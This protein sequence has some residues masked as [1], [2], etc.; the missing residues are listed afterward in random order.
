LWPNTRH[1]Y[2]QMTAAKRKIRRIKADFDKVLKIYLIC[3]KNIVKNWSFNRIYKIS[4]LSSLIL[5][6]EHCLDTLL[7]CVFNLTIEKRQSYLYM[8]FKSQFC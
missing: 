5:W 1:L 4:L 2:R 6:I 3:V 8:R 7:C